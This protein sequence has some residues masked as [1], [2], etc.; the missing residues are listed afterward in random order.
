MNEFESICTELEELIVTW[1]TILRS[2]NKDV[3]SQ[4]RNSQNRSI[5]QILGHMVDSATN[6]THRAIHMQ[7]GENPLRFPNYATHGNNDRWI[8]IQNYRDEDWE[9]LVNLWKYSNLHV[10]HVFRNVNP[11]KL[12][13]RWLHDDVNGVTLRECIV[14]FLRYFKLHLS[15]IEKLMNKGA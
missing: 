7:Y 10:A 15:E 8:A 6:N 9:L 5:K 12:E 1:E 2:L 11:E 13:N 4:R 14:D 3:I